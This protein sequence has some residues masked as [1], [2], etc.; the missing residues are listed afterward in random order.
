MV[1]HKKL[2]FLIILLVAVFTAIHFIPEKQTADISEIKNKKIIVTATIFPVYDVAKYIIGERGSVKM[3]LPPGIE[4][5]SYEPTP[6]DI[7]NLKKSKIFLYSS[8]Y[9]ESWVEKIIPQISKN[10]VV[11]NGSEGVIFINSAMHEED[12]HEMSIHK[13]VDPHIWMDPENMKIIAENFAEALIKEEPANADYYLI[14]LDNYK[15]QMN[16]LDKEIR[17]TVEKFKNKTIIYGGHY[18]FGYFSKKYGLNYVSPY[19][20]FSPNSDPAPKDIK[21]M[22]DTIKSTKAKY[23][24]YEEMLSPK[25]AEIA[26]KECQVSLLMLNGAHN[27]SKDD[28]SAGIT[29][30]E[31]MR[32][33]L[34][35][36][37]KGLDSIE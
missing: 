3:M 26:S 8:Q 10:C 22:I 33:N 1:S 30:I 11:V 23:I 13:G 29:Y 32:K 15:K 35:N 7:I 31:I 9:M 28:L 20:N 5:H 24:F 17:E 16:E 25:I 21:E 12:E 19:K 36:L 34:E 4:P 18:A 2:L 27:V 14:R 6:K 37:K